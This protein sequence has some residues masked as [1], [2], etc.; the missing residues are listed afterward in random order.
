MALEDRIKEIQAA[1]ERKIQRVRADAKNKAA[2]D[3]ERRAARL[4]EERK[5]ADFRDQ[6]ERSYGVEKH[7]KRD[8]LWAKAWELGHSSGLEDVEFYYADLVELI[9]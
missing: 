4:E 6:L 5:V 7:P 9:K 2:R 8:L 1:A 3:A